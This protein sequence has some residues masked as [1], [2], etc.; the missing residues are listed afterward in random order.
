MRPRIYGSSDSQMVRSRTS[1]APGL[2]TSCS[3]IRKSNGLGSP[4]GRETSTTR[5]ADCGMMAFLFSGIRQDDESLHPARIV[6]AFAGYRNVV[7]V[8]FAQSRTGNAYKLR[9]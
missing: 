1:P 6:G 8:A 4:T 3:S 2:G 9:L 5:L 7:D